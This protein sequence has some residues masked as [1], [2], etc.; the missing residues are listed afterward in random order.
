MTQQAAGDT[1]PEGFRRSLGLLDGTMLVAGSMI[2]SGIF[3]VSADIV[4]TT[5]GAGWLVLVWLISGF[6]TVVGALSYAELAAMY[7][8]AGGQYVYLR[9]AWGRLPAFLY[10]W[11]F[12]AVIQTGSIAAVGVAFAKFT[13]YLAPSLGDGN[14]LLQLGGFRINAA[15]LVAIAV[16][17]LLSFVNAR[18]VQYG[19][20]IQTGFT[21]AKI[22]AL[23]ALIAFGLLL[24][25]NATVWQDNWAQ[26]WQRPAAT[27]AG[28]ALALL[29]AVAVSMV[30][31]LFSSDSW[32]S[33]ASV[34]DEIRNPRRN[35][36]LSLLLGTV[37]V[38]SLYLIANL[39]YLA[40]LPLSGIAGADADRVGVAAAQ[41]AFGPV[42]TVLI[43]LLIMVSTFG[44]V[45]GLVLA[46]ARVYYRM[47]RDGLFFARAGELNANAVPGW[48][49][50]L[51]ALWA[52][53]LCL[54]GR[55]G[56]LLDYVIF[57]TLIFY[58]LTIAGLFR[59]RHTRADVDRPY[60]AF[61]YPVLPAL[62]IVFAS[63]IGVSLLVWK[64]AYTWPGL[65]IVLLGVP[66]FQLL[67]ARNTA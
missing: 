31:A 64:P 5:G 24:G 55:Y 51:Q 63:A 19:K 40:V 60:R 32:H 45:N 9:E 28:M 46:G 47:A 22:A 37:L 38:C 8:R 54:S 49:L 6:M 61:G 11:A 36:G 12:F 13:A 7:P 23:L 16:V 67:R 35:V 25:A 39:M 17:L 50:W 57:A 3:I 43:A 56:D 48:A 14:V 2:G 21:L 20:W 62:Y 18:G 52:C 15:Q 33:A 30:G 44:C 26:A 27:P 1:Q 42:G 4:R 66:V 29:P 59:L 58:V 53:V 65:V 10:G 34:A 41:A